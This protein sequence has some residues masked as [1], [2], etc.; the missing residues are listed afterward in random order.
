M[1]RAL[2]SQRVVVERVTPALQR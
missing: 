1:K 2:D